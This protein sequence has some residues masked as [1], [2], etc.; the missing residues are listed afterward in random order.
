MSKSG[1]PH[2]VKAP[3]IE[4]PTIQRPERSTVECDNWIPDH[5]DKIMR[6]SAKRKADGGT[7]AQDVENRCG[8]EP[9]KHFKAF[10]CQFHRRATNAAQRSGSGTPGQGCSIVNRGEKPAWPAADWFSDARIIRCDSIAKA[11]TEKNAPWRRDQPQ[12]DADERR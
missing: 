3:K 10:S 12:M 1:W 4:I 2:R 9:R 6:P 7:Y 8:R 11:A 5:S